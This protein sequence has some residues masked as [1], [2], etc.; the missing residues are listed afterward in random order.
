MRVKRHRGRREG[1]V[2]TPNSID[3]NAKTKGNF[4][5]HNGGIV[6]FV[7]YV[8]NPIPCYTVEKSA[9]QTDVAAL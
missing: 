6:K 2:A 8:I 4:S 1:A 5:G 7:K 3:S 9:H